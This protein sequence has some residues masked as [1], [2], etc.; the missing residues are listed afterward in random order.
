MKTFKKALNAGNRKD[1]DKEAD[2]LF[3]EAEVKRL[4]SF[5]TEESDVEAIR[6]TTEEQVRK[7]LMYFVLDHNSEATE[8]PLEVTD[9]AYRLTVWFYIDGFEYTLEQ[10]N[11]A[12]DTVC[13]NYLIMR[14]KEKK[15]VK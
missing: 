8:E 11:E 10:V 1:Y 7:Y 14:N 9:Y 4:V 15:E 12:I 3:K 2:R 13:N 6:V 5:L